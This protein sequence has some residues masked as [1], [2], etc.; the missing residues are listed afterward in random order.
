MVRSPCALMKIADT[1]VRAPGMRMQPTQSTPSL[2]R[3]STR[4]SPMASSPAGPPSGAA[5]RTLPPSRTMAT[6]ALAAQPPPM[7]MNS[8]ASTFVSGMGNSWTR[9]TSSRTAMPAQRMWAMANQA[10]SDRAGVGFEP[11][12]D[13]VVR[14][15]DRMGRA[16]ALRV[17]ALH[18]GGD[19]IALEPT[20]ILQLG[21]IDL[22]LA[23]QRLGMTSDHQ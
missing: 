23:R 5:N 14:D 3:P 7:V 10:P 21:T 16:Q 11:R 15:R 12:P 9:N 17:P 18:H 13:D 1:D 2:C 19:L 6:A 22:E 4:R 8:A 20:G